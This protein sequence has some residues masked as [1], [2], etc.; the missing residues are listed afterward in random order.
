[1]RL[2]IAI[3]S[4]TFLP[5]LSGILSWNSNNLN[6]LNKISSLYSN[7]KNIETDTIESVIANLGNPYITNYNN[8][9]INNQ[10]IWSICQDNFGQM[11]FAHRQGLT[12]FNGNKWELLRLPAIPISLKKLPEKDII[13][14]GCD[15][16]F[17][18]VKKDDKGQYKYFKLSET[19]SKHG[20]ITDIKLTD[21]NIYFYSDKSLSIYNK[22]NLE[23]LNES[24]ADNGIKQSGIIQFNNDIFISRE[25][26]GLYKIEKDGKQNFIPNSKILAINQ[27]AFSLPLSSKKVLLGTFA[28]KTLHILMEK[29]FKVIL[30]AQMNTLK[31]VS[32]LEV[33]EF[34]IT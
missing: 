17:G 7:S 15:E 10:Q 12:I 30:V 14:I 2:F 18:F 26:N 20:E 27:F 9:G 4:F 13:L 28:N 23:L 16:Q 22:K 31:K 33:I 21:E 6:I 29:V 32:W 19:D 25:N 11:I 34:L 1:M 3:I 5:I 8:S 24:F